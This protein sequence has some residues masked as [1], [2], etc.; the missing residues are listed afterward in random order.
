MNYKAPFWAGLLVC[1]NTTVSA[2]PVDDITRRAHLDGL[3]DYMESLDAQSYVRQLTKENTPPP[4]LD[5]V[6]ERSEVL[7][8]AL[9]NAMSQWSARMDEEVKYGLGLRQR[10]TESPSTYIQEWGTDKIAVDAGALLNTLTIEGGNN[11]SIVRLIRNMTNPFPAGGNGLSPEE[12]EELERQLEETGNS[13]PE[14][15]TDD[16]EKEAHKFVTQAA[17]SSAQNSLLGIYSR[18]LPDG[19]SP[20]LMQVM[21]TE[22]L[23]RIQD[24]DWHVT[25]STAP[26]EALLR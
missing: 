13:L 14:N 12:Q 1:C 8:T 20:S 21:D 3:T 15:R 10:E 2:L 25:I 22:A 16:R 6:A 9:G 24:G 4:S 11:D 23:Y 5:I 19:Q 17:L 26:A 18:R 7:P